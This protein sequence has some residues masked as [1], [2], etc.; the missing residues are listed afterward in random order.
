MTGSEVDRP[1]SGFET[2]ARLTR[3]LE[4]SQRQTPDLSPGFSCA[5]LGVLR[6]KRETES[7]VDAA[8]V[9]EDVLRPQHHVSIPDASRELETLLHQLRANAHPARSWFD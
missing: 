5:R 8:R 2:E 1:L 7:F 4:V 3:Q 6:V 9:V